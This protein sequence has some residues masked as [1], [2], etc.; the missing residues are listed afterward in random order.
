MFFAMLPVCLIC[1]ELRPVFAGAGI[2]PDNGDNLNGVWMLDSVRI[3]TAQGT[4]VSLK[5][6]EIPDSLT[7]ICPVEITVS[8]TQNSVVF[9]VG[10]KF[11]NITV[12]V[13]NY[14]GIRTLILSLNGEYT[15]RYSYILQERHL[16]LTEIGNTGLNVRK[17]QGFY[18]NR[19]NQNEKDAE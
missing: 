13:E 19:E 11:E 14:F 17:I 8:D 4:N 7:E 1:F 6:S 3:T 12:A 16:V 9:S 5:S 15:M 2:S 10:K 18:T